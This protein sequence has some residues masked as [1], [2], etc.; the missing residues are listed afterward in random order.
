M[1]TFL[2]ERLNQHGFMRPGDARLLR[3]ANGDAV[4]GR[5]IFPLRKNIGHRFAFAVLSHIEGAALDI[6]FGFW[7]DAHCSHDRGVEIHYGYRIFDSDERR[8]SAVFP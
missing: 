2:N 1:R 3:V 6:E 7:T 8:S 5:A 4:Q